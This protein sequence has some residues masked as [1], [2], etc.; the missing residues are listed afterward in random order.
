MCPQQHL[1]R[2]AQCCLSK[3]SSLRFPS[4]CTAN[5]RTS[6]QGA[7]KY[8]PVLLR[9]RTPSILHYYLCPGCRRHKGHYVENAW[10]R[11]YP[12]SRRHTQPAL[13]SLNLSGVME[14]CSRYTD[15]K[16]CKSHHTLRFQA[17]KYYLH[18]RKINPKSSTP[19]GIATSR[20]QQHH[21][22]IPIRLTPCSQYHHGLINV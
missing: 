19:A 4:C 15:T 11:G 22:H 18:G 16:G 3:F 9:G 17:N 8:Q 12:R 21:W 13:E 5:M 10:W 14:K 2:W 7:T 20:F 1:P 6:R